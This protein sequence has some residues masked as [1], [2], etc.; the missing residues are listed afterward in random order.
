MLDKIRS[1]QERFNEINRQLA[2]SSLDYTQV[3]ELAKE[4]SDLEPLAKKGRAFEQKCIQ[5]EEAKELMNAEDEE[6]KELAQMEARYG[7]QIILQADRSLS[8]DG[9][10]LEFIKEERT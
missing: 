7:L 10:I 5:L 9:G 4:R 3:A 8:P 6:L 2:D 1:I